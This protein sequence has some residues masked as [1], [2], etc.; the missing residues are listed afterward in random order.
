[1]TMKGF[2][3]FLLFLEL[4]HV[5]GV[6]WNQ[7]GKSFFGD[8]LYE[9]AYSFRFGNGRVDAFTQGQYVLHV[10]GGGF[11]PRLSVDRYLVRR[12]FLSG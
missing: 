8:S 1:M 10:R 3:T 2:L 12:V 11:D 9:I 4:G 5:S 6:A 7:H